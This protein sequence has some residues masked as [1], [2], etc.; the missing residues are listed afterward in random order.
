MQA[1]RPA[2]LAKVAAV[3]GEVEKAVEA[4]A[5]AVMVAEETVAA[6]PAVA[7]PAAVVKVVEVPVVEALAAEE[8]VAAVPAPPPP[9]GQGRP[10]RPRSRH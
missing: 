4:K 6:V 9:A 7:E 8:A 5:V 3:P 1:V 10:G 2:A